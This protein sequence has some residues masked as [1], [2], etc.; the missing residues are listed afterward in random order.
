MIELFSAIAVREAI[1]EL[2]PE[3][4]RATGHAVAVKFAVNPE[5]AKQI[6][7]GVSFDVVLVN[8]H[9][10]DDLIT[11]GKVRSD[12][13]QAS[14]HGFGRIAM[15]VGIKAGSPKIDVSTTAAFK[16]SL[17]AAKSVGYT[18]E[19]SSGRSFIALLL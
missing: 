13:R 5:V 19:G 17:L 1:Q 11:H 6:S 7:Q 18:S 15:G 2:V 4:E 9:Y 8:P 12:G 14:S 16:R 3:F 10:I